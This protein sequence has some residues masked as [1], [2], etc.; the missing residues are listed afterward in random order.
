M[1]PISTARFS[2]A[3]V[4]AVALLFLLTNAANAGGYQRTKDGKALVWNN[5]PKPNDEATWSGQRDGEGYATGPGTLAWYSKQQKVVTGSNLPARKAI[6]IS[7]YTGEMKHG[8]F[9]G[10][11]VAVDANGR[12]YHGEFVDGHREHWSAGAGEEEQPPNERR[13]AR[14]AEPAEAPA[15]G[16]SEADSAPAPTHRPKPQAP[17]VDSAPDK[18]AEAEAA[19][20]ASQQKHSEFDDSLKSLVGPPPALHNDSGSN[21]P[22]SPAPSPASSRSSQ[23]Q[24]TANPGRPNVSAGKQSEAAASASPRP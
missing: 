8:K 10:R 2:V 1:R 3:S 5:D 6:L 16:P 12:K 7:R 18:P 21:A 19:A 15:E 17:D 13:T 14:R 4:C 9:D 23:S 22:A 20:P 11:V 24:N